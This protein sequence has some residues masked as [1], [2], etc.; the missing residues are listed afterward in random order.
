MH[1]IEMHAHSEMKVQ[2]IMYWAIVDLLFRCSYDGSY[3]RE[4]CHFVWGATW[5]G[6]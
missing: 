4:L 6:P 2:R 3:C 1:I 5:S